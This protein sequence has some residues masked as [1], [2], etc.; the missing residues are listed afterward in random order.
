MPRRE[1]RAALT[2]IQSIDIVK[3]P[4]S[5]ALLLR[6]VDLQIERPP[7][8]QSVIFPVFIELPPDVDRSSSSVAA[9]IEGCAATSGG[10]T[11]A[12]GPPDDGAASDLIVAFEFDDPDQRIAQLRL[13]YGNRSAT[14]SRTERVQFRPTD[15]A[16]ERWR[17]LGLIIG[18]LA[19]GQNTRPDEVVS[20]TPQPPR[21]AA[22]APLASPI[23]STPQ[24]ARWHLSV[25]GGFVAG[26]GIDPSPSAGLFVR[27][28]FAPWSLPIGATAAYR[29]ERQWPASDFDVDL[30]SAS[31]GGF[32]RFELGTVGLEARAEILRQFIA[33]SADD[34]ASGASET[35]FRWRTG[36]RAGLDVDLP[37]APRFSFLVGVDAVVLDQSTVIR[38]L[39]VERGDIPAFHFD[40][41]LAVRFTLDPKR[42]PPTANRSTS[43][44]PNTESLA[45][46]TKSDSSAL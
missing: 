9:L 19:A 22:S 7:T 30:G 1:G 4:A 35:R 33:L 25:D 41:R 46:R 43:P 24:R 32:A 15:D 5:G 6:S 38:V 14:L 13:R 12:A 10:R 17:A 20:I 11:C 27:A 36:F 28:S 44:L 42:Q 18:T 45:G 37:L 16:R 21:D 3:E 29:Q 23:A 34:A 8:G 2:G 40:G 39:N 31:L 26:P